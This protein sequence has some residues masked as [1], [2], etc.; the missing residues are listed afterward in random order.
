M[1]VFAVDL[2]AWWEFHINIF[3]FVEFSVEKRRVEVEDFDIPVVTSGN[4]KDSA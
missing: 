3:V 1:F 2:V 4:G